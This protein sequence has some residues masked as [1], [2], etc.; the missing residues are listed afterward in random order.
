[1][2]PNTTDTMIS[3]RHMPLEPSSSTTPLLFIRPGALGDTLLALP[4]LALARQQWPG[5]ELTL[6]AR[7][8][9]GQLALASQLID[10]ASDYSDVSWSSIFREK[11]PQGRAP[12]DPLHKLISGGPVVAWLN[13]PDGI[14][15]YN[16]RRLGAR[17]IILAQG[18]PDPAIIEHMAVTLA[19]GLA[20]LGLTS[21]PSFAELAITLSDR[22][23][24]CAD[25]EAIDSLRQALLALDR[26]AVAFHSGSGGAAK[27]WPPTA[28][29]SLMEATLRH[30]YLPILLCGPQD[31]DSTQSVVAS[32][33][34]A[35]ASQLHIV[36]NL[37]LDQLTALLQCCRA[38]VGN[39][40]GVTHLAALAGV[41]T[42]AMFGPTDPTCWAPLGR[43]VRILPSPTGRMADISGEAAW[44]A[45]IDLLTA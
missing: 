41:P 17:Q 31:N 40:C 20:P 4:T 32:L 19:R 25:I 45:L 38:Y 36:S 12:Q 5:R 8:D 24:A 42:L 29:G 22:L 44:D 9:V 16:L 13:D 43:R 1:L 35:T 37:P 28:F 7:K 34:G 23:S 3:S 14:V 30:G 39:D 2:L 33:S 15:E 11:S 10:H 21:P 27:R 18:R 26:P 6:V